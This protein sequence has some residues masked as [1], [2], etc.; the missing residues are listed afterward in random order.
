LFHG[1]VLLDSHE[2]GFTLFKIVHVLPR[3]LV[4]SKTH[5]V[6]DLGL[7]RGR[8][9]GGCLRTHCLLGYHCA[10]GSWSRH[11]R[12]QRLPSWRLHW[13]LDNLSYRASSF[14]HRRLGS[15]TATKGPSS[16]A[17]WTAHI[18][19]AGSES[20]SLPEGLSAFHPGWRF[21]EGNSGAGVQCLSGNLLLGMGNHLSVAWTIIDV[22]LVK[23][24]PVVRWSL[25]DL[26]VINGVI[27]LWLEIWVVDIP[28]VGNLLVS[29]RG[30]TDP[31]ERFLRLDHVSQKGALEEPVVIGNILLK[32]DIAS[33]YS[34][35][36]L[37]SLELDDLL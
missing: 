36:K 14:V 28:D 32:L 19:H 37:I 4:L 11:S 25:H 27:L 18:W 13:R 5:L 1:L 12:S 26:Q 10:A 21:V 7:D 6:S 23:P 15:D 2:N 3:F 35:H 24:L 8:G 30:V 29:D 17:K 16:A 20:G 34:D 22:E 33:T 31:L 9:Q